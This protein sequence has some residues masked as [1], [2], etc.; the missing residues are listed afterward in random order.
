[1]NPTVYQIER[2]GKF[3]T[4]KS[5][6]CPVGVVRAIFRFSQR[7][8]PWTAIDDKTT[9]VNKNIIVKKVD[10]PLSWVKWCPA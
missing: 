7:Y 5:F 10:I 1:M 4:V 8:I 6:N 9:I 3:I 2:D